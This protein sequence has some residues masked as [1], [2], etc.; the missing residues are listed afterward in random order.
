MFSD[1]KSLCRRSVTTH[2][3]VSSLRFF[4]HFFNDLSLLHSFLISLSPV[5]LL[6]LSN[7]SLLPSLSDFFAQS[8]A[9]LSAS[10]RFHTLSLASLLSLGHFGFSLSLRQARRSPRRPCVT[11][12]KRKWLPYR[13]ASK[14]ERSFL[15]FLIF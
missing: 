15:P 5:I 3:N 12:Y 2:L 10:F 11:Q 6:F 9:R 1:E 7:Y 8:S 4:P 13:C 14:K